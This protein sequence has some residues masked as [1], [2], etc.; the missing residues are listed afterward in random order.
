MEQH[1]GVTD[2]QVISFTEGNDYSNVKARK[3]KVNKTKKVNKYKTQKVKEKDH[4]KKTWKHW[5]TVETYK[6]GPKKGQKYLKHHRRP[7]EKLVKGKV[8]KGVLSTVALRQFKS[9]RLLEKE[10]LTRS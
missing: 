5:T 10:R 4:M 3:L 8:K 7:V 1:D 6:R 9:I 2:T